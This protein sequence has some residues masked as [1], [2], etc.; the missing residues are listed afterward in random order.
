M[1]SYRGERD[2]VGFV[3]VDYRLQL[4]FPV[5]FVLSTLLQRFRALRLVEA[6]RIF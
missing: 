2:F 3:L 6:S 1:L 5:E 4:D